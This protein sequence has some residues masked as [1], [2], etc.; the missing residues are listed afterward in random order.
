MAYETSGTQVL[1]QP[2]FVDLTLLARYDPHMAKDQTLHVSLPVST[3]DIPTTR[4]ARTVCITLVAL[5]GR[6]LF[7]FWSVKFR[8]IILYSQTH[9]AISSSWPFGIVNF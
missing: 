4:A 8:C 6:S 5:E 7:F 2:V 1:N 3:H 9:R